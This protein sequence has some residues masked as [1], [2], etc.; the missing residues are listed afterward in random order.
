MDLEILNN[1]TILFLNEENIDLPFIGN[2]DETFNELLRVLDINK[3]AEKK[4]DVLKNTSS[5]IEMLVGIGNTHEKEVLDAAQ[6]YILLKHTRLN[7]DVLKDYF[8]KYS[9]DAA[10]VLINSYSQPSEYYK[11]IFENDEFP[12]VSKIK[13]ADYI[14]EINSQKETLKNIDTNLFEEINYVISN[15]EN[16]T[17]KGLMQL[18][19]SLAM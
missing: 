6:A 8:G 13:L 17:Q 14:Y 5:V 7:D 19:K 15:Y 10:K 2:I 18:L 11:A 16:K 1:D 3:M 9:I 4:A 12:Y